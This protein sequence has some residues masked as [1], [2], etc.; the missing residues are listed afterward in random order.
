[1]MRLGTYVERQE[2]ETPKEVVIIF[3]GGDDFQKLTSYERLQQ[4][5]YPAIEAMAR[6]EL[7]DSYIGLKKVD[8]KMELQLEVKPGTV[9]GH[10]RE[11]LQLLRGWITLFDTVLVHETV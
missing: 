6:E 5:L 3:M 11:N 2:H 4:V 10:R 1:M 8:K 9:L 7:G